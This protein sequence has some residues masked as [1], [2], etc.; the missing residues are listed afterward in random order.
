MSSNIP[1]TSILI[2]LLH[3]E[4]SYEL[5]FMHLEL[6]YAEHHNGHHSHDHVHDP[7]V[8][9]VSIVCE[10][11]LDLEKVCSLYSFSLL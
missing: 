5:I 3:F 8:S 2:S 1:L 7:G 10:G 9:S 6:L 4:H 11:N